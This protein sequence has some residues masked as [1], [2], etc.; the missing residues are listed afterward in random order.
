MLIGVSIGLNQ[1]KQLL[2][3]PSEKDEETCT[4]LAH[5]FFSKSQTLISCKTEGNLTDDDYF[6]LQKNAKTAVPVFLDF[7]AK[8]LKKT[9]VKE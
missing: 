9:D 8:S 3:D 5:F 2:I 1:K 7:M 6:L 4:S